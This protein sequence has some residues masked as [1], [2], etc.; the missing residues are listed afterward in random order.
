MIWGLGHFVFVGVGVGLKRQFPDLR[1]PEAG[2][3]DDFWLFLFYNKDGTRAL[4]GQ[5]LC[6]ACEVLHVH[7]ASHV[8]LPG[9]KYF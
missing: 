3:S 4:L 9:S 7:V 8:S 6:K 1:Y 5:L 2:I